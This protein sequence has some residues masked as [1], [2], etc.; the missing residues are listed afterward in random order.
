MRQSHLDCSILV[1][2]LIDEAHYDDGQRSPH[3]Y[4][5]RSMRREVQIEVSQ[6]VY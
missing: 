4:A 3:N 2:D 5:Q 1:V 6:T